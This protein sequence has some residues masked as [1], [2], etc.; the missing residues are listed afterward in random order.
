MEGLEAERAA[1][2]AHVKARGGS[3]GAWKAC[4]LTIEGRSSK[5]CNKVWSDH[6]SPEAKAAKA[7]AKA[8]GKQGRSS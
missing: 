4:A 1:V 8:K 7:K 6:L 3:P 5:Q 2:E